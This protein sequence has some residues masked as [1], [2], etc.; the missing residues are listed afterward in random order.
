MI[1]DAAREVM[2]ER[3]IDAARVT[4]VAERAGV[5]HG[6]VHYYFPTKD[7]LVAATMRYAAGVGVQRL[8]KRVAARSTAA[9]Q[10]DTLFHLAI[11]N[12]PSASDAWVL[13]VDAWSAGLRDRTVRHVHEEQDSAWAATLVEIIDSGVAA[14]EFTCSDPQ[15]TAMVL[16]SLIDGL[17]LRLVLRR[18]GVTRAEILRLLRATAAEQLGTAPPAP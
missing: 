12:G 3:G 6:L 10:L 11:P 9:E 15:Q 5:S 13:W 4:D 2:V 14:G 8:R 7:D 18:R 1:L 17:A 16:T